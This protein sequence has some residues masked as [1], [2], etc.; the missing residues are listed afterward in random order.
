M[1]RQR[2][3]YI[4][5]AWMSVFSLSFAISGSDSVLCVGD[6][7]H[8]RIERAVDSCCNVDFLFES[9]I[10][11]KNDNHDDSECGGC[12]D[13]EVSNTLS[14]SASVKR[15][16]DISL[17][18]FVLVGSLHS[19]D[20]VSVSFSGFRNVL[21]FIPATAPQLAVSTTILIC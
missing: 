17:R 16:D 15:T 8:S 3:K 20:F 11:S 5:W 13:I 1:K 6:E 7:G 9:D 18:H 12:D 10:A 2:Q 4:V 19:I 21:S 14:K